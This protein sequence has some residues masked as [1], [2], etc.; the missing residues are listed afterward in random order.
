MDADFIK[1]GLIAQRNVS[2]YCSPCRLQ[3]VGIICVMLKAALFGCLY[4]QPSISPLLVKGGRS[5]LADVIDSDDLR[6]LL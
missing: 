2:E 1:R 5:N 3:K 6:L 4:L